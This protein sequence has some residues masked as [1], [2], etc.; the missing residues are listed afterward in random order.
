LCGCEEKI[1]EFGPIKGEWKLVRVESLLDG[2]TIHKPPSE[3]GEVTLKVDDENLIRFSG[4]TPRNIFYGVCTNTGNDMLVLDSLFMTK[5]GETEWGNIFFD[6]IIHLDYFYRNPYSKTLELYC[7]SKL[8]FT[9][10]Q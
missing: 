4:H 3:T 9:R 8:V 6:R 2:P 5:V 7:G 1:E 10:T